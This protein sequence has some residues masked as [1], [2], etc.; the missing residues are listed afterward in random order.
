[1]YPAE[2]ALSS[3]KNTTKSSRLFIIKAKTKNNPL[4][5]TESQWVKH[6]SLTQKNPNF[7]ILIYGGMNYKKSERSAIIF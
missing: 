1:M 3:F 2:I 7:Y 6:H 5:L 4:Q